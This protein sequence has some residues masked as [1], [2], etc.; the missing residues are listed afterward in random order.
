MLPEI[1][2]SES[3]KCTARHMQS[4]R[5]DRW[6]VSEALEER[7]VT[8][9]QQTLLFTQWS[10][11]VFWDRA[12]SENLWTFSVVIVIIMIIFW[13]YT[14]EDFS[15]F[16]TEQWTNWSSHILHWLTFVWI[17]GAARWT[18]R[19]SSTTLSWSTLEVFPV[20]FD[21]VVKNSSLSTLSSS[22]RNKWFPL[23]AVTLSPPILQPDEFY[24]G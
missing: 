22:M 9:L 16:S 6:P 10:V 20:R 23:N 4:R 8:P 15:Y 24:R 19:L 14:H 2:P 13:A 1:H 12:D 5:V 7:G 21:R 11:R 3:S 17:L 18:A